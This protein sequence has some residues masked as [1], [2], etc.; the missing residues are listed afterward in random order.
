MIPNI[1]KEVADRGYVVFT[2]GD[3]N[4]NIIGV[5]SKSIESNKFD[6]TM[7]IVFK[8]NDTWIQF[9]FPITTDPGL[10]YLNN[11]MGVNGTAIV[12]EGQYRGI[13]KLGLH[14][15]SYEALVQTG[16]KIKIYRDR[17]KDEILDHE[18]TS[19]IDGYF[20]IN[21]HRASTRTNSNNVDK[22]SAGCQVFQN[23]YAVSY[24]HLTLPTKRI[25]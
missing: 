15:G 20:G 18:P 13:Y 3:Y 21:I 6:D 17:N 25:V 1:L 24:T 7:Y 22:W 10:Y 8:Q 11:P 2:K 19:L 4:L 9:K 16:G 5:R 12:C 14:R 23:A